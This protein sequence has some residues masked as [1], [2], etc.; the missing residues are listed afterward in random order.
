MVLLVVIVMVVTVMVVNAIL[1]FVTNGC[2]CNGCQWS[3]RGYFDGD[4]DGGR[5]L[6]THINR[7]PTLR[8]K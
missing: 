3:T 4:G 1:V 2:D 6:V 7:I 5:A 8:V